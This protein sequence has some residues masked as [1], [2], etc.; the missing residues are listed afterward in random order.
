MKQAAY[1]ISPKTEVLVLQILT[2]VSEESTTSIFRP[3]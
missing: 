3:E 2:D 1:L